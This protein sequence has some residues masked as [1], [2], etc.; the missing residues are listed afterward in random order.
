MD[1]LVFSS[2]EAIEKRSDRQWASTAKRPSPH[3]DRRLRRPGAPSAQSAVT[4]GAL[5][6]LSSGPAERSSSRFPER[7]RWCV[8]YPR[9]KWGSDVRL[10]PEVTSRACAHAMARRPGPS[11]I[12][13][14][15][16]KGPL[17][18]S[19]PR[20]V[21]HSRLVARQTQLCTPVRRRPPVRAWSDPAE[22]HGDLTVRAAR[23]GVGCHA[24]P[25]GIAHT[26]GGRLKVMFVIGLVVAM[27]GGGYS[28][29]AA[30][31]A[32]ERADDLRVEVE[33]AVADISY[34]DILAA[35][36]VTV[37]GI[38]FDDLLKVEQP[39]DLARVD[40]D[41]VAVRWTVEYLGV[42]RCVRVIWTEEERTVDSGG[43]AC[44]L[45][46]PSDS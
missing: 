5:P 33:L 13:Y 15:S 28:W 39:H 21:R 35:R 19:S 41:R 3:L 14:A 37:D 24:W 27:A 10:S 11:S 7:F 44:D 6:E 46:R 38:R 29:F 8:V 34:E 45:G 30:R 36:T 26:P 20:R 18:R 23:V 22:Y 43:D 4:T 42:E 16:L 31:G 9:A 32:D 40:P 12:H 1:M 17:V 25:V 2:R